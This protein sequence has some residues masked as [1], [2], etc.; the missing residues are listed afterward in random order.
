MD[1]DEPC[2]EGVYSPPAYQIL[3]VKKSHKNCEVMSVVSGK[4]K[5]Y[6]VLR[7]HVKVGFDQVKGLA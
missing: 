7:K 5:E 4:K 6:L 1:H 3:V 2:S